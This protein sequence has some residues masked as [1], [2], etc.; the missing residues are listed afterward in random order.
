MAFAVAGPTVVVLQRNADGWLPSLSGA[1]WASVA[2]AMILFA[3]VAALN[4]TAWR[5]LPRSPSIVW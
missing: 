1:L 2:A 3:I 4:E 5:L